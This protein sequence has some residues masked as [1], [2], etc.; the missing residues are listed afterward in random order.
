MGSLP[1]LGSAPMAPMVK[2]PVCG[3]MVDPPRAAGK[4]QY[5]GKSYFFC[6]PRCKQRFEKEPAKFLAAP[7][8]TGIEHAP[9]AP[10]PSS[11]QNI[12]YTSP[13]HPEIVQFRPANSP[14][15]YI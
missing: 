10:P 4:A 5:A 12:R 15:S 8:T 6:S 1:I 7:G 3:M 2:D 9:H 13:M 14:L 11:A